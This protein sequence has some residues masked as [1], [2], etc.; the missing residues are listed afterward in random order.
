MKMVQW[1]ERIQNIGVKSTYEAWEVHLTRKLNLL[2]IIGILNVSLTILFFIGFGF[3]QFIPECIITLMVGPCVIVLN[4]RKN[5]IW[6]GYLFY[7]IGIILFFFMAIRMG[8]ETFFIL[9]YFPIIV[10]LIHVFGR[11][12]TF[13]HLVIIGFL[14]FISIVGVVI[15][16]EM[17]LNTFVFTE[18]TLFNLRMFNILSGFFLTVVLISM[19]TIEHVKQETL[20]KNTL[21]EK[22]ILLAEVFHR[23]KN[24]MTIVTSLLNLKMHASGSEEVKLALQECRERVFSMALVHQKIYN[25]K[26]ASSLNFKEYID[27]LV[28]ESVKSIGGNEKVEVLLNT[29]EIELPLTYAIPCGLI[30]N[31]LITNA[32]KHAATSDKKLQLEIGFIEKDE[33]LYLKVK[34]NGPGFDFDKTISSGSLGLE[35]V[36]SLAGQ[37]DGSYCVFNHSG[38]CVEIT[39]QRPV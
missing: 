26:S 5:Y 38:C 33:K 16:Q 23:V 31:E 4:S 24:N 1:F 20:I 35:L 22:E 29:E 30:L 32:F 21:K 18:S 15:F 25:N 39:F 34:D 17:D 10:S 37:I 9:F 3:Y 14:F 27:D 6:A 13:K 11:K 7:L 8:L 36:K 28:N 19:L 12:E 2:S